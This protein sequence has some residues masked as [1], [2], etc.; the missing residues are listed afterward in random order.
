[1]QNTVIKNQTIQKLSETTVQ[2]HGDERKITGTGVYDFSSKFDNLELN[3]SDNY[4]DEDFYSDEFEDV[5][6]NEAEEYEDRD[7]DDFA[8]GQTAV[9]KGGLSEVVDI[10]QKYL[11]NQEF[12]GQGGTALYSDSFKNQ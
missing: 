9:Q 11:G 5:K 8:F 1:M 12:D 4:S 3:D 10:Y 2:T 7:D 6:V